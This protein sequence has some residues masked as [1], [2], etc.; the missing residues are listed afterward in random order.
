MLKMKYLSQPIRNLLAGV[1]LF[2][3]ASLVVFGQQAATATE[4]P[5]QVKPKPPIRKTTAPPNG[6]VVLARPQADAPQV[7][8]VV[9]QLSG[10]KILRLFLRQAGENDIVAINEPFAMTN[11]VH[12]NIIAGLVLDG[13]QTIAVWLPQAAAEIETTT[14]A[15]PMRTRTITATTGA[16]GLSVVLS[17]GRRLHVSYVGL[18]GT[19][20]VSVLRSD[21]SAATSAPL[22]KEEFVEGQSLR[23]FAPQRGEPPANPTPYISPGTIFV[24]VGE[25]AAKI[26]R[27][28]RTSAGKLDRLTVSGV[29]LSRDFVGGIALDDAGGTVG[30]VEAV[31]GNQARILPASS[32]DA[33][34]QRVL[35][36]QTSVPRPLLGVQGALVEPS[37]RAFFLAHGWP[38]GELSKLFQNRE[39]VLLTSVFPGTPAATA[40]LRAGDVIIRI[41]EKEVKSVED[42]TSML[43][44]AGSGSDVNFTVLRPQTAPASVAVKLGGSLEPLFETRFGL[45][46]GFPNLAGPLARFGL[47]TFAL[48]PKFAPAF[49]TQGLLVLGVQ[50]NS[51]AAKGGL[52]EGDIIETVDGR[53]ATRAVFAP[54]EE[55]HTLGIVRGNQKSEIV[56]VMDPAREP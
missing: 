28:A 39:G 1:V 37:E 9:H 34:V 33:A 21:L 45:F 30:I 40:N 22:G 24:R 42:F 15:G 38:E 19:T 36:R 31:D 6:V 23:I 7:V 53:P 2:S 54:G 11:E 52:R 8:T 3:M 16:P 18:D 17:D 55:K 14:M 32:I 43:G 44:D 51:P 13:G 12:T 27:I 4:P 50:A 35:A 10:L 29:N 26:A 41:N 20:G 48:S 25:T 5:P 46:P 47:E 49:G 56:V